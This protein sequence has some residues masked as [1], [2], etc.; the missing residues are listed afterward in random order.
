[1]SEVTSDPRAKTRVLL[2]EEN[3]DLRRLATD[4]LQRHDE[5]LLVGV[6]RTGSEA[7]AVVQDL[8]PE[9]ILLDLDRREPAGSEEIPYLREALPGVGIIGLS[10][11]RGNAYRQAVL[12]AGLDD[13]VCKPDL[14]RD[15]LPAV[16][17]LAAALR[18]RGTRPADRRRQSRPI[19]HLAPSHGLEA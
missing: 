15:L 8:D 16:E 9:V 1:M 14:T 7:L 11:S 6:S 4:L 19:P 17:R 10:L 12:G 5:V 3:Q 13:L 2:V 18:F